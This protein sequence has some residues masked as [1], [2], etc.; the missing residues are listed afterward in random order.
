MYTRLISLLIENL[1][2]NIITTKRDLYYQDVSLFQNQANVDAIIEDLCNVLGFTNQ[3]LGAVAAQKGLCFG[4]VTLLNG[5]PNL[6]QIFT[7]QQGSFLIPRLNNKSKIQLSNDVQYILVVEKDAVFNLLC[8][9][10]NSNRIIVTGKGFPDHLTKRFLSLLS[11]TYPHLPVLGIADIDPYGLNIMKQFK[12]GGDKSNCFMVNKDQKFDC[13][14]LKLVDITILDFIK[15]LD[16]LDLTIRDFTLSSKMLELDF[17][18]DVQQE[19]WRSELQRSMFFGKKA[20]IDVIKGSND[21]LE[22]NLT[23]YIANAIDK[24]MK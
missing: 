23:Q 22:I 5:N 7:R 11:I 14:R 2:K 13:P 1:E 17:Y 20:E 18:N 12:S 8:D 3:E 24:A 21:N 4:D 15:K 16:C 9:P 19:I 10:T 6:D